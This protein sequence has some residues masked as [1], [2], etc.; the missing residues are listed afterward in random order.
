MGCEKFYK[1]PVGKLRA[2]LLLRAGDAYSIDSVETRLMSLHHSEQEWLAKTK[3]ILDLR[4]STLLAKVLS[5][6]IKEAQTREAIWNECDSNTKL[7]HSV[8]FSEKSEENTVQLE[9]D[10]AK[11]RKVLET[12]TNNNGFESLG[13][14]LSA[15]KFAE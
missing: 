8:I 9:Q 11:K 15:V 3:A 6:E 5:L 12:L 7:L 14:I 10:M 13:A 2:E 4:Q 1:T